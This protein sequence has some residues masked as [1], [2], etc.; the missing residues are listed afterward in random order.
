MNSRKKLFSSRMIDWFDRLI[1]FSVSNG[2]VSLISYDMV[3]NSIMCISKVRFSLII[4]VWLCS[5]GGSLLIRMVMKM[6]LL[7][8]RIILSIIR[9]NR[10]I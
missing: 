8:L 2:L 7:M 10:L 9:V 6:R 4:W 3:V 5:V 1:G